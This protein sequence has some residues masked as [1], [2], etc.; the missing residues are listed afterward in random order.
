MI[1]F[2][3]EK[4]RGILTLKFKG[5]YTDQEIADRLDITLQA[6]NKQLRKVYQQLIPYAN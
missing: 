4:K 2:A 3:D 6:V 1:N 5:M